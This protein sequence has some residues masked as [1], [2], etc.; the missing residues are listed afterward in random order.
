MKI[1]VGNLSFNTTDSELSDLFSQHGE[2]DD[3]KVI[4]DRETGRSRGFGFV[5]MKNDDAARD[6]ISALDGFEFGGRNLKVNEAR[7][8]EDR[9]GGGGGGSRPPRRNRW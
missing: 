6:A 2:V 5:E 7:P 1:Y 4:T 8:R 9:G 3:V